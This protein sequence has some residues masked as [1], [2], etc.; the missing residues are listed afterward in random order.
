MA[1]ITVIGLGPGSWEQLSLKTFELLCRKP[2]LFLRTEKHPLVDCLRSRGIAFE[3]FD[4]LYDEAAGFDEVYMGIVQRLLEEANKGDIVYAVPG[5]PMV[6]ERSVR[7]LLETVPEDFEVEIIPAMSCLDALFVPLGIDPTEGLHIVDCLDF[8]SSKRGKPDPYIPMLCTQLYNSRIASEV[9]L[10]LMDIYPDDHS[11]VLV[12]R[13]GIAGEEKTITI[14]LYELDRQSWIDY[15]TSLLVP[16]ISRVGQRYSPDLDVGSFDTLEEIMDKLRRPD[17]CP[18]DAEQDFVSLKKYLIEETYEVIEAVEDRDM[19]KLQE[20]LGDLLLQVIFYSQIAKE[21]DLFDVND[22]IRGIS[23]KLIRRHPHVFGQ[24]VEVKSV[25]DVNV[26]WEKIKHSEKKDR[27]RFDIPRKLPALMRAEKVQKKAADA[28]FDWPDITGA[29]AKILEELDELDAAV[30]AKSGSDMKAELGD[31]LF[32]VVN[33]A[34]FLQ[35]DPEDALS[36]TIDKF[37]GRF[38]YI[39]SVALERGTTPEN[40]SLEEMDE[41]WNQAK[42]N[43]GEKTKNLW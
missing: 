6:A 4:R 10:S 21:Q 42:E 16:A 29:W 23:E 40:M 7:M 13:A 30:Q 22:V 26:N 19:H 27:P 37:L 18:W 17:G 32:A 11:V 38:D 33:T 34:R 35:V 36:G 24:G 20:E 41:L 1:R 9:K 31:L 2:N 12:Q 15:L 5:H 14:P 39:E 8:V 43:K 3:S 25:E 28:G